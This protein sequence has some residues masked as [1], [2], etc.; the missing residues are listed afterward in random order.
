[1]GNNFRLPQITPIHIQEAERFAKGLQDFYEAIE[2]GLKNDE[3]IQVFYD[4]G[5]ERI[6]V[7]H[8]RM[9]ADNVLILTGADAAGN[10]TSVAGYFK[11]MNL[12]YKKIKVM[13]A[14]GEQ[15]KRIGFEIT[16][17]RNN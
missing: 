16:A 4:T 5:A 9:A 17:T 15:R 11:S 14:T 7:H 1:M 2:G 13:N 12:I 8:I 10:V 3:E 6:L